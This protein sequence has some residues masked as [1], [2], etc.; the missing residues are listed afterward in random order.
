MIHQWVYIICPMVA[1]RD[2]S[3]GPLFVAYCKG[4]NQYYAESIAYRIDGE[5]LLSDAHLPWDDCSGTR[6]TLEVQE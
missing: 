1:S 5:P 4:C 2:M 3:G 6:N